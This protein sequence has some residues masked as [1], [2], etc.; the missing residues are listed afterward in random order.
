MEKLSGLRVSAEW[1]RAV[2]A[3]VDHVP[4][5]SLRRRRGWVLGMVFAVVVGAGVVGFGVWVWWVG[6]FG[7]F[8]H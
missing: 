7:Y 1:A 3:C 2:L 8:N 5:G 6:G 4:A